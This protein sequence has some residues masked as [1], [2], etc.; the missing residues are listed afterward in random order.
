VNNLEILNG[1]RHLKINDVRLKYIIDNSSQYSIIPS[2]RYFE[3]LVTSIIGQQ[4]SIRAA[5]K[6]I[7]RF[8]NYFKNRIIPELIIDA[9]TED[10]RKLGISYS[11]IKYIKDLSSKIEEKEISFANISTKSDKEIIELLTKI[12]GI[13]VWTAQMFL[14]FTLGRLNVLP[15]GDLGI[16]KAIKVLYVL[17]ELPTENKIEKISRKYNWSPYNS[18]AAWYLW[19]SL[20]EKIV[21]PK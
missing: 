12:K 21:I 1:I 9:E 3:S 18:I 17:K 14:I 10:L 6:I 16:K 20:D 5:D 7:E 19:K 8:S 2:N 13:G 4:L 11:K 15:T